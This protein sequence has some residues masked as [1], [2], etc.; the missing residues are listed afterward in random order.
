M[1]RPQGTAAPPATVASLV[2]GFDGHGHPWGPVAEWPGTSRVGLAQVGDSPSQCSP[3]AGVAPEP[4]TRQP[5][6]L[7]EPGIRGRLGRKTQHEIGPTGI[8]A[9]VVAV[10]SDWN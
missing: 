1:H 4:S 9:K 8:L 6:E 10:S 5:V 3:V 7:G 2:D